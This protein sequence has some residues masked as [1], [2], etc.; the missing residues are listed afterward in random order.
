M[1]DGISPYTV[2]GL[3]C[4]L[5]TRWICWTILIW[6]E[7]AVRHAMRQLQLLAEADVSSSESE[8]AVKGHLSAIDS[9]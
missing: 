4:L 5:W 2:S 6:A 9:C 1:S 7:T 8:R 3:T